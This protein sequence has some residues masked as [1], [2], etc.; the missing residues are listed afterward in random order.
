MTRA[1][2][3]SKEERL[4]REARR[5]ADLLIVADAGVTAA[6]ALLNDPRLAIAKQFWADHAPRLAAIGTLDDL[7]RI[8]LALLAVYV[9]DFVVAQDDILDHGFAVRVKTISGDMMPRENPAV[10]RRDYAAKMILELGRHF[11]LSKLDRLNLQRMRNGRPD[12]MLPLADAQ[13]K[14]VEPEPTD[15]NASEWAALTKPTVN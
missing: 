9:G 11:G 13:Q 8:N 12:S 4:A 2:C 10:A 3:L 5:L 15:T 14:P 6:P 7:S 1:P